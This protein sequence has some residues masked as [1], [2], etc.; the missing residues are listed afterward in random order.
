[1]I[2][3]VSFLIV[4]FIGFFVFENFTNSRILSPLSEVS[5]SKQEAVDKKIFEEHKHETRADKISWAEGKAEAYSSVVSSGYIVVDEKG[6]PVFALNPDKKLPPASLAKLVTAMVAIDLSG[7][8]DLFEVRQSEVDLE[9]TIIMVD[10]GEQFTRDELLQASLLTSAN[11]AA[12]VLA[13]GVAEK[14][15]GSREVFMMLMNEKVKNIGLVSTHFTNP[16]G[17]DDENQYSTARELAKIARYAL[18]NYPEIALLVATPSLTLTETVFRKYY[19]L[20][21]WNGLLGIYPGVDGIKIGYTEEAGYVTI[22]RSKRE[23][24]EFTAVLLGVPDRRARDFWAADLLN[25]AFSSVGIK[26]VRVTLQALKNKE[27]VWGEQ[28]LTAQEKTNVWNGQNI[29][30]N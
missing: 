10:E 8:D 2:K 26:P 30:G 29:G 25:A 18:E 6:N 13:R 28:L 19:E 5:D 1:M 27:A 3:I 9:P 12:E 17:Y 4:V 7:K 14:L 11:D 16:T 24:H 22:V 23:N 21:N 15:G 20:P